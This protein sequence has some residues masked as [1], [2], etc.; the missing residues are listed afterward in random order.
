MIDPRGL[1]VG[2]DTFIAI[3]QS[4][5]EERFAAISQIEALEAVKSHNSQASCPKSEA[6]T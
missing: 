5:P 4:L 3:Q 2:L 6:A 1:L